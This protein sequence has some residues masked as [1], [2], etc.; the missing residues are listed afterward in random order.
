MIAVPFNRQTHFKPMAC[1]VGVHVFWVLKVAV[2]E[3][4]LL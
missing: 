3:R 2:S 4:G 1:L